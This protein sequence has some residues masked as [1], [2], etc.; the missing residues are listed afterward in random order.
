M[1]ASAHTELST[2]HT[3]IWRSPKAQ[4][5]EKRYNDSHTSS[6][7]IVLLPGNSWSV[8]TGDQ[9]PCVVSFPLESLAD[10]MPFITLKELWILPPRTIW[11]FIAA[12]YYEF[13]IPFYF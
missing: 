7:A 5:K 9:R 11:S 4:E 1:N 12:G 3:Y 8:S 6:S 10:L 13:N 2:T